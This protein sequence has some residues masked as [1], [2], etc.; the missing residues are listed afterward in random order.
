MS[1][2]FFSGFTSDF[3]KLLWIFVFILITCAFHALSVSVSKDQHFP[4]VS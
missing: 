2:L 3:I 4:P 1:E